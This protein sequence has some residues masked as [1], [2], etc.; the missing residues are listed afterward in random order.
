MSS[1]TKE[2]QEITDD[3][4]VDFESL[5]IKK[6]KRDNLVS[7]EWTKCIIEDVSI[8][9]GYLFA[10]NKAYKSDG[11]TTFDYVISKGESVEHVYNRFARN[12]PGVYS[13]TISKDLVIK[14]GTINHNSRE[15]C[16]IEKPQIV[17]EISTVD[18][19]YTE[20]YV[21]TP[22]MFDTIS[23]EN[24]YKILSDKIG[25]EV[26]ISHKSDN[27]IQIKSDYRD[28]FY[29]EKLLKTNSRKK[30][31]SIAP[32][33][34]LIGYIYFMYHNIVDLI[35]SIGF[36]AFIVIVFGGLLSVLTS[37]YLS[38]KISENVY[39]DLHKFQNDK[40]MIE[41]IPES[42]NISNRYSL[43]DEEP[44]VKKANINIKNDGEITVIAN[45]LEWTFESNNGVPSDEAEEIYRYY[46]GLSTN[47]KIT[48]QLEKYTG[49][50]LEDRM[51]ISDCEDWVMNISV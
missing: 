10:S 26:S 40:R 25:E 6:E 41:N 36:S 22:F 8:Y 50:K 33:S 24:I 28:N 38:T 46:G 35:T 12:S 7:S 27:N 47:D 4:N 9:Q 15:Y 23:R 51:F 42:A 29:L 48:V 18:N 13:E 39:G 1:V 19:E 45:D 34:I 11:S 16:Y 2:E 14:D 17:I 30:L 37:V 32:V 21:Y 43:V 44:Q 49:Q 31:V 5:L 3:D 20:K